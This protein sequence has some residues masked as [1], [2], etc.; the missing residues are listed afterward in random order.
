MR[1]IIFYFSLLLI[2]L[3]VGHFTP[4]SPKKEFL[5]EKEIA[6]IQDAQAIDARVITYL[7]AAALRLQ[8]A[9]DRLA[10]KDSR[11]GDPLEFF[12]PEDLLDGYYQI[13]QSI[14]T[15]LDAAFRTGRDQEKTGRAL[16]AL[17]ISTEKTAKQLD[18][19][20][21]TAE[22]KKKEELW[23]LVN[24]A[25]DITREAHGGAEEGLSQLPVLHEKNPKKK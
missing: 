9:Q 20:K 5:T 21:K 3:S 19:L 24:K 4:A 16:K 8:A 13:L 23:D 25:I 6:F 11:E 22:E 7:D 12:T 1:R 10:G 18:A 15:N 2:P 17:S 14:I